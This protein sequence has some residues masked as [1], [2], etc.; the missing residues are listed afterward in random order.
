MF[1]FGNNPFS[2]TQEE[3]LEKAAQGAPVIDV[4]SP[5]EFLSGHI[6]QARNIP[7]NLLGGHLNEIKKLAEA[8]ETVLL[9]CLSGSRSA[10]AHKFLSKNGLADKVYDLQG[11]I[12]S[13]NGSL[14]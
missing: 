3:L 11:G 1:G 14:S 12:G 9:Y 6:K 4:R 13:W 8:N 7:V 5:Q 2:I 10:M